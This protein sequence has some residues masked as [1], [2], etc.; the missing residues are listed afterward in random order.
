MKMSE[1]IYFHGNSVFAQ[2]SVCKILHS[3]ESILEAVGMFQVTE[4]P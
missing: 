3:M 1:T 4:N 2:I